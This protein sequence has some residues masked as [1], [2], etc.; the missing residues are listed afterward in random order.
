MNQVVFHA[1]NGVLFPPGTNDK[2]IIYDM[3]DAA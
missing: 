2:Q 1:D 3:V